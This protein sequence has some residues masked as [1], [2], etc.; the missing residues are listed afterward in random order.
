MFIVNDFFEKN[1]HRALIYFCF[2]DDGYSRHRN[3]VFN[4]WCKDLDVSIEK[5]DNKINY[6]DALVYGSLIIVKDNPLKKL[7]IDAFNNY[8][9]ELNGHS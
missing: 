2:G 9:D 1:D 3:I 5:Y 4:Q 8:M 7:I 6:D